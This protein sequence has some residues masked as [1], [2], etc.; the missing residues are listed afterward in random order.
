MKE[1]II[2]KPT[3]K[4]VQT[5]YLIIGNESYYLFAQAY[6]KGVAKFYR[7]GVWLDKAMKHSKAH[8]DTAIMK[9]M[10]KIP[11]Y[12]RY[13]EKEYDMEILMRTRKRGA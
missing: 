8:N 5:F 11:K 1:K 2:C 3:K 4:G 12:V 10:D 7:N 9:A 6:R 13:L